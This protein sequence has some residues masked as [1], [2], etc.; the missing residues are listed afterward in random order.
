MNYI[1]VFF[2]DSDS[3]YSYRSV[4]SAGGTRK[5]LRKKKN[6][7]GTYGK[8]EEYDENKDIE[9]KARRQK[10]RNE[11]KAKAIKEKIEK[12][13]KGKRDA[14]S[15]GSEFSYRSVV[16]AGGTRKV[17]RRRR[18]ADGTYSREHSYHSSQDEDGERRRK[19]RREKRMEAMRQGK[20]N[21]DS[22]S[23]YSYRSVVS[24]GGTRKVFRKKK[25]ADGTYGKE[26]AY[27]EDEDEAG[28]ERRRKRRE[29]RQKAF[30]TGKRR[31]GSDSDYSYRSVVS[32]GG[33][34]HVRRKK[35]MADGAYADSESYHSS[36]D[37]DGDA[38]R[39]RR[40]RERKHAGSAHRYPP[41]FCFT[42]Y[43]I[44]C[45]W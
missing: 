41:S 30:K 29:T 5:V 36:Q 32:A 26:E 24:A 39:R 25:N 27:N 31:D 45:S 43:I 20:L 22:D 2:A 8:E 16:S 11:R 34:R 28:K 21:P 1:H 33:T 38:R 6:E 10:R 7:D 37:E 12:L 35:K 3:E 17:M 40:R 14:D 4:V 44:T 9:G 13:K 15:D 19:K 23:E 18:K 42:L